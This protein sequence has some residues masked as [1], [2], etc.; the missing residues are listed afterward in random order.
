MNKKKL[1]FSIVFSTVFILIMVFSVILPTFSR[2]QNGIDDLE[3]DGIVASS[4]KSGNG[5]KEDPYIISNPNELAYL[6]LSMENESYEGKYIKL[7][8]DIIINK[9]VFKDKMYIYDDTEYYLNDNGKY[10]LDE[11]F[12]TEIGSINLIPII[13]GF[14]GNFDGDFHTIYGLYEKD[15]DKNALFTDFSGEISNLY[16][17][18]AYI[19]GGYITAGVISDANN[20]S[21]KNIIFNGKVIGKKEKNE[22]TKTIDID[23]FTVTD[24]YSKTIETNISNIPLSILKGT[25]TGTDKFIL[26]NKEYECSNFEIETPN[27][28]EIKVTSEARFENITYNLTYDD[29]KTS[30]IVGIAN[31]TTI[32][33]IVNKG[34]INGIYVSGI[35]GTSLNTNI[36]NS[37]NNGKIS[38]ERVSGIV[39]TLMYSNSSIKNVYNNGELQEGVKSGLISK[40]YYSTI[41]V[42]KVFNT[43]NTNMINDNK[44][45]SLEIQ[46][47]YNIYNENSFGY[48]NLE[49]INNL[50]PKYIDENNISNGN[51]WVYE[52]TPILYFDDIKNRT[53]QVKIDNHIWD[54]FNT[55]YE[56]TRFTDE[57]EVL[58]ST[59]DVYKPIKN[60]WYYTANEIIDKK[61][62]ETLEWTEYNGI[63]KLNN[64]VYILYVKYEDYNDNVYYISTD[65]LIVGSI[66]TNVSINSGNTNWNTN[67]DPK[68]MFINKEAEYEVVNNG[69]SLSVSKLEYAISSSAMKDIDLET[70]EWKPYTDKLKPQD[71][72]YIIYVKVTDIDSKITYINTDK[73]INMS[74][75]ISNTEPIKEMTYN[76]SFNFDVELKHVI[77]MPK[78][79]RYIKVNK[80]LP[81]N[82]KITLKDKNNNYYEYITTTQE[83]DNSLDC[84]LYPLKEFKKAGKITFDEYFKDSDYN[85]LEDEKFNIYV[86]FNNISKNIDNYSLSI[87]AKNIETINTRE[88]NNIEFSLVDVEN[89]NLSITTDFNNTI[90]YGIENTYNINLTTSLNN[91]VVNTNYKNLY[92]GIAIE[93]QDKDNK[94]VDRNVLGYLR[95]KYND[96]IYVLDKN[97][98]ININLGKNYNQNI[99]LQVLT[100]NCNTNIDD[101]Y[102]IKIKGYLSIDG[103][104][105][106]YLSKNNISIPLRLKNNTN[107]DYSFD[108][109]LNT[110]IINKGSKFNFNVDYD[111]KLL[112]PKLKVSLYKK[113]ELTAY[114]QEYELVDLSNYVSN[115]LN[116]SDNYKYDIDL[117]NIVFNINNNVESNGYKF[118]FELYDNENKIT[119][120]DIKTIIR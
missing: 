53:V 106:K 64:N 56:N 27:N 59:T 4:F 113:K 50:Y 41:S 13:K 97:N 37:Y 105:S 18:N 114:N 48:L 107:L 109:N 82:T 51:I 91:N 60:V 95:F 88:N 54:K 52:E 5:T 14:K 72:S 110:P 42:D 20:A 32:D 49:S 86:D 57:I 89:N 2:F 40:L 38:G 23:D 8:K 35:I 33:G 31:N 83:K 112:N 7:S 30:G 36:T 25:C 78:Y 63:F 120:V 98:K 94:T 9:G 17:D 100:Y 34:N 104:N 1:I 119:E 87:I 93:I 24:T 102:Y 71:D 67:H 111:G 61:D 75:K 58:I 62:L 16:I 43:Y 68:N 55:N 44:E 103:I 99:N 117:D 47:S 10:Y 12:T 79:N 45:S 21:I 76:S 80:M 39:D 73:M 15:N 116:N 90:S 22:I 101:I 66:T 28:I 92:E 96:K 29:N 46:N 19:T 11:N 77:S 69:A 115:K 108:V 118:V 3:W 70:V 65:K 81:E 26:N 6:A 85:N 74:Y 84:Y